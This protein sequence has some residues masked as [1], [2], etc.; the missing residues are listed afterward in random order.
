[1]PLWGTAPGDVNH[2]WCRTC[3][4][5]QNCRFALPGAKCRLCLPHPMLSVA[6]PPT[7]HVACADS[8]S[9][10][11]G[12]LRSRTAHTAKK[13]PTT[14][15]VTTAPRHSLLRPCFPAH[16][17]MVARQE[18][19]QRPA[20]TLLPDSSL[21]QI[22]GTFTGSVKEQ[23]RGIRFTCSLFLIDQR[24]QSDETTQSLQSR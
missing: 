22:K 14:V 7:M 19:S 16:V 6:V 20:L 23:N 17:E 13:T 1:M 11:C 5:R 15:R 4:T 18:R 10:D 9:S 21:M 24:F 12:V 8:Q 3:R 2:A